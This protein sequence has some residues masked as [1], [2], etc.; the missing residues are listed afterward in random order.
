VGFGFWSEGEG[1]EISGCLIYNNGWHGPDRSHGH[2]I[3]TQN[4]RGTK[5]IAD[6]IVFHQFAYGIHGYGS[7]K[8]NLEGFDVEGN[9]C[10]Q[11]GCLRREGDNA[12][13][14]LI[15]G[16]CPV[17][18]LAVRD[19]VVVAGGIRLGYRWGTVS[20]DVVCTGNYADQGLVLRDFKKATIRKN[21]LVASSIVVMLEGEKELLTKGLDWD[22][23]DY[24]ITEGRWG[25][26]GVIEHDKSRGLT[27]AQWRET[28]GVDAKTRFTKGQPTK[29][30]VIVR[31]NA[32]EKGR[33]NIAIINPQSLPEVE[34]DLSKVL[35]NGD[36]YRIVSA[37]DFYGEPLAAGTYDGQP[38]RIPMRP[39]KAQ[40]VVG[41]PDAHLPQTEPQF[42]AFVVL[43]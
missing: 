35:A 17:K 9:I 26:T 41:L 42:G 38:A 40:G 2:G 14:I 4:A 7:Q 23:N 11:N 21:T 29:L 22:D 3:Y 16:A 36:K 28:T 34:V 18:R 5:R 15:G 6:N 25:D 10:F 8:A 13:G 1:G 12:P 30:R 43:K 27:F 32:H 31:P 19:N 24:F 39:V 33:A 20:D 37:K